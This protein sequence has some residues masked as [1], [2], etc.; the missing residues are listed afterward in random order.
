MKIDQNRQSAD[1]N[2]TDRLNKA[3][4]TEKADKASKAGTTG[5][6]KTGDRVEMSDDAKLMTSALDAA[7]KAP[8][9]RPEA[10]ERAKKLLESG[11]LGADAGK[12]ADSIIDDL[13]KK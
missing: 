9:V 3:L 12:L 1:T 2:A 10:V 11:Q 4:Q 8:E 7:K 6:T 5:T 13:L